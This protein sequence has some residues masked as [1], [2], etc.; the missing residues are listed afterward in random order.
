MRLSKRTIVQKNVALLYQHLRNI[1]QC[2]LLICF[3]KDK[4]IEKLRQKKKTPL[5]IKDVA[6]SIKY[7][8]LLRTFYLFNKKNTKQF[9]QAKCKYNF[10]LK[11]IK[12]L[13]IL[14]Y[15][16]LPKHSMCKIYKL[17]FIFIT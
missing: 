3:Y 10:N 2:F 15:F 5:D 12:N 4:V 6:Y 8:M 14:T 1:L 11:I 7:G 13:I 16:K 9:F 17:I